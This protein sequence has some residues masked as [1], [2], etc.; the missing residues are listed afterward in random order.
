MD[1]GVLR[2][3]RGEIKE[4]AEAGLD[5][6]SFATHA[7]EVLRRVVAFEK[8]CW[9]TVDPGTILIT[10]SLNQNIACSGYWLAQ[11]EYVLDDVN[12]YSYLVSS[13]YRA[14][15]LS[16]ATHGNL[17]LSARVRDA[18][19]LGET[20]GDE[21]RGA[22]VADGTYWG[23]GDFIRE[24]NRPWFTEEEVRFL[25]SLSS[26]FADGFRRAIL[27]PPVHLEQATEDSPG[28]VVLGADGELG[29]ISSQAEH[30]IGELFEEPP[31][32]SPHQARAVQV[33]AARA[34]LTDPNSEPNFPA[35]VRTQTRAGRW[36]LVYGTPLSGKLSGWVAVILQPAAPQ[37]VAPLVAAAYGLTEQER[38]VTQYCLKG[39]STKQVA[40]ALHISTYT[41]QDHLKSIFAKTGVGSRAELLG[42]V[43]LEHYVSRLEDLEDLPAGWLGKEVAAVPES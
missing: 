28:I 15:S 22:F 12:K 32:A 17:S 43:F 34:R 10:G 42:Q 36:L 13:G 2:R 18:A 6:V 21:L 11:H 26:V 35:R 37:E 8:S 33:V 24:P 38:R 19:A 23:G 41:V 40:G 7:T 16:A 30:W 25:A 5:W 1:P 29:S 9:H 14:G 20:M 31:P 39:F 3:A 27:A 4:I